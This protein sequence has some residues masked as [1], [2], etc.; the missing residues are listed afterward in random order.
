MN[1][2]GLDASPKFM[3]LKEIFY[4]AHPK[5]I[6]I[7]ETMHP[8]KASIAFFR[9]M[10]PTWFMVATEANGQLGGL[11]VLWDPSWIKAKAFKC[12]A[13][14][15]ISAF[16]RG[17]ALVFNI[18]NVYA[19]YR[20]RLSFWE[21][22]FASEILEIDSLMIAGDLNVTLRSDE[23]WGNCRKIDPLDDKLLKEFLIRNL[24]DIMPNKMKPTRDNSRTGQAYIAKRIDRFIIHASIIEKLGMSVSSIGNDFTSDH[25]PI[26]LEWRGKDFRFDYSF[27]F[28]RT[29]LEDHQQDSF[30]RSF[31]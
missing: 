9:R 4:S 7:Q 23:C 31:L 1:I 29:H 25:R 20:N 24:V 26:F 5:I 2:R 12:C 27:K 18:L 3:V 16:I 22:L 13:K 19:P 10:F 6:F 15:L 11:A 8:S 30:R 14:I 21:R 28:N 17:H